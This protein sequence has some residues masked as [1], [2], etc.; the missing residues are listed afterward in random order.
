MSLKV[1][2]VSAE[3]YPLVKVGGLGD[4]A[5]SLPVALRQLGLDVSVVLPAYSFLDKGKRMD[6]S[7]TKNFI[8]YF[9]SDLDIPVYLVE[10][11][12][13]F[14]GED[15]YHSENTAK[16]FA[17]FSQGA[18]LLCEKLNNDLIHANDWHA[19][20]TLAFAKERDLRAKRILSIHNIQYQGIFPSEIGA[21]LSLNDKEVLREKRGLNFLLAGIRSCDAFNVVSETYAGEIRSKEYGYGLEAHI[22]IHQKKL[23]GITN[24]IDTK[25]WGPAT[26]G[27]IDKNYDRKSIRDKS[28]NKEQLC[29]KYGLDPSLP[30]F[31]MVSRLAKQKG[32]DILIKALPEIVDKSSLFILGTGEADLEKSL[33]DLSERYGN[34]IALIR[35]DEVEAHRVYAGGDFFLMPSKFEPCGLGQLI[36]MRY[37][38]IPVVRSTGGL[39]ETVRDIK[40]EGWGIRF[41][42]LSSESL[43]GAIERARKLYENSGNMQKVREKAIEYDSS[44][45]KAAD[46]YLRMYNSI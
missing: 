3:M 21:S 35:Y 2:Y 34:L 11:K 36:A 16:R 19:S 22:R 13:L 18:A 28:Y 27:F 7:D 5:G 40:E 26:D 24:G 1:L 46:E 17:A 14:D 43:M 12:N 38:T 8:F 20:L 15:I 31:G 32:I 42:D 25:V 37:G 4:V 23:R 39:A 33:S 29:Q 41:D 10:K 44:W 6:L 9:R 30:L 45:A